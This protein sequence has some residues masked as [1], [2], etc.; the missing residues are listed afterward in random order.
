MKFWPFLGKMEK[1]WIMQLHDH[2]GAQSSEI[3]VPCG[4]LPAD[5]ALMMRLFRSPARRIE[6]LTFRNR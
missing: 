1:G 6:P 2:R 4:A 5:K 3:M